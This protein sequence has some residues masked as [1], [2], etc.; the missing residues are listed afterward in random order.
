[1]IRKKKK[2]E[3]DKIEGKH[4]ATKKKNKER[5]R[6]K[7]KEDKLKGDYKERDKERHRKR[8]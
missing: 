1:M 2:R 3:I 8:I 6:L 5:M 4:A 7:R